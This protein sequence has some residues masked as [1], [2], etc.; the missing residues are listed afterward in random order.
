MDYKNSVAIIRTRKDSTVGCHFI[1]TYNYIKLN[2]KK[3]V[4][5]TKPCK[6][7]SIYE[8]VGGDVIIETIDYLKHSNVKMKNKIIISNVTDIEILTE[9][10]M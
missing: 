6:E 10:E 8:N 4:Y 3:F 5:D 1:S 2:P 9:Y 7:F